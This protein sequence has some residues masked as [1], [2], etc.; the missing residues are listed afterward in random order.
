M[1]GLILF[2]LCLDD[3]YMLRPSSIPDAKVCN[4]N[5]EEYLF[6]DCINNIHEVGSWT[7]LKPGLFYQSFCDHS[8]NFAQV[9]F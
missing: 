1:R 3:N 6:F 2:I 9:M 7:S 5:K 4:A 8:G